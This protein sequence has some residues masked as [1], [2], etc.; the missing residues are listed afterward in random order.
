MASTDST[1]STSH[2]EKAGTTPSSQYAGAANPKKHSLSVDA[3]NGAGASAGAGADKS[4][5]AAAAAALAL[6]STPKKRRI[7]VRAEDAA[8]RDPVVGTASVSRTALRGRVVGACVQP[9][10]R[11]LLLSLPWHPGPCS[12]RTCVRG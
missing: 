5:T 7:S 8:A 6:D 11:M 2:A 10:T 1:P 3:N 9:E 4:A 12:S